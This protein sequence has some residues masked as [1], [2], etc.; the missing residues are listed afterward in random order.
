MAVKRKRTQRKKNPTP[1]QWVLMGLA[2]A[3]V[4][5]GGIGVAVAATRRRKPLTDLP[6][7]DDPLEGP[8]DPDGPIVEPPPPPASPVGLEWV[9]RTASDPGYPWEEPVLHGQNYPTPAMWV[10]LN[11]KNGAF[12]P[13]AGFDALV[14]AALGSAL[15]MAGNDPGI[16]SAE[17]QD[18]RAELGRRLRK[19]MR[20]LIIAKGYV[21]DL[22]YGQTNLNL[23]GGNDPSAPHGDPNKAMSATHVI[24]DAGRGLSWVPRHADNLGRIQAGQPL[25]RT[26]KLDGAKLAPPD[27]GNRQMIVYIPA[28]DLDALAPDKAVPVVRATTWSDGTSTLD[29]PPKIQALGV[30]MSGV[31]LPGT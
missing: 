26:T 14:R 11:N 9:L 29:P 13:S 23:A 10:D 17:G 6:G 24:N 15:A 30:D 12:K 28:V 1:T 21:N 4:V 8:P 27:S 22:T 7:L 3:A 31:H 18:P 25:K 16:A 5:F 2:G 20:Q 19:Q